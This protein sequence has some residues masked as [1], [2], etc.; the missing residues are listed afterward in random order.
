MNTVNKFYSAQFYSGQQSGSKLSAEII[1]PIVFDKVKASSV[2]DVGC[3]VGTWLT[4]ARSL[5]VT[6]VSLGLGSL[7]PGFA[8]C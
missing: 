2:V 1:L 8:A 5:G 3:G 7:G 4:V 6:R